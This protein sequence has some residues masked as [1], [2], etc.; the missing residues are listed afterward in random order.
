MRH[1]TYGVF[2]GSGIGNRLRGLMPRT[3]T[4][5]INPTKGLPRMPKAPSPSGGLTGGLTLGS[6]APFK[7]EAPIAGKFQMPGWP[8]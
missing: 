2:H 7:H 1:A 3:S 8:K 4:A 6:G 5:S